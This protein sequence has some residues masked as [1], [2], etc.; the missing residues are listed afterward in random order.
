MA[1]HLPMAHHLLMARHPLDQRHDVFGQRRSASLPLGLGLALPHPAKQIARPRNSG[2][3]TVSGWTMSRTL[4][5]AQLACQEHDQSPVAPGEFWTLGLPFKY[6][7]LLVQQCI[8]EQQF[9][10]GAD[11]IQGHIQGQGMVVRP[12]PSSKR[13]F[14]SLPKRTYTLSE[15]KERK[16]HGLPFG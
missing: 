1:R 8:F 16:I 6:D 2:R 14:D 10:L 13:L 3:K 15:G 9:R 7:Y 5:G 12:C 4:P 11:H